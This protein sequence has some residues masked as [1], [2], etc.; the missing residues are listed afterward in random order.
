MLYF[1]RPQHNMAVKISCNNEIILIKAWRPRKKDNTLIK[2]L[3]YTSQ[4]HQ[5]KLSTN[6]IKVKNDIIK[7]NYYQ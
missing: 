3:G 6:M 5:M 2:D 4:Y 7:Q 1:E